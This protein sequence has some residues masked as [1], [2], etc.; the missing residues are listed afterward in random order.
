MRPGVRQGGWARAL[1]VGCAAT[2]V[3]AGCAS[4]GTGGDDASTDAPDTRRRLNVGASTIEMYNQ[5]GLEVRTLPVPVGQVWPVL[6]GVYSQLE[7]PVTLINP[8]TWEFGN[9]AFRPRRVNGQRLNTFID[10]GSNFSG[11]LANLYEVD[12]S[13]VTKLEPM[14]DSTR[15]VTL[16]DAFARARTTSGNQVHCQSREVLEREIVRLVA[17][18]LGFGPGG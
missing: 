17:G 8:S 2:L 12:M 5:A 11:P 14:S 10:C 18:R 16:V 4:T 7:I 9:P 6:E 13:V 15:V 1:L 3:A